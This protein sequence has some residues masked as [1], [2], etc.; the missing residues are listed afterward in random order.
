MRAPLPG[1]MLLGMTIA[2][3]T[4]AQEVP[5]T[6]LDNADTR[7]KAVMEPL[8]AD[9]LDPRVDTLHVFNRVEKMPEPPGTFLEGCTKV[10]ADDPPLEEAC[11]QRT[12]VF[13]RF[14]VERDGRLTAPAVVKGACPALD[15][16]AL[17]CVHRSARWKPGTENGAPVRVQVVVP[18]RFEVR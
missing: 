17:E 6:A 12:K 4:M 2:P 5:R 10:D 9:P 3:G 8:V 18:V 15:R 11:A 1:L 16:L 13:V 14:I 7:A